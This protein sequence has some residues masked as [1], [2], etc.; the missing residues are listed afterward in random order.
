MR[1]V[2][3]PSSN[4]GSEPETILRLL[5]GGIERIHLRKPAA[6]EPE[7]RRLIESLPRRATCT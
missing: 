1:G 2:M 5:E 7:M 4:P 3:R 6:T